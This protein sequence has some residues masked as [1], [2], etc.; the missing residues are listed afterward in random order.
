M[1][2]P[3]VRA[4]QSLTT[5]VFKAQH[6]PMRF[7]AAWTIVLQKPS[8]PDYSEPGAWRPIALLSTL[9]KVIETLAA[10]RLSDLAEQKNLLPDSQMGNRRNRLV[11]TALDLLIEQ[12]HTVW[13]E[14]GQVAS[15]LSLDIAGAFNTVNHLQLLDNLWKKRI[16]M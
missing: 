15:V 7:H 14:G 2:D 5:A 6:F 10:R 1:G 12:I 13:R 11:E 16:P 8:K 3:L 4:L 9:G